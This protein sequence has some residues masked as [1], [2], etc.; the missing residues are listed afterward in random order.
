MLLI[1]LQVVFTQRIFSPSIKHLYEQIPHTFYSPNINS[2]LLLQYNSYPGVYSMELGEIQDGKYIPIHPNV[3]LDPFTLPGCNQYERRLIYKH[4]VNKS[5]QT[6]NAFFTNMYVDDN[7]VFVTRS[8]N[9]ILTFEIDLNM[10]DRTVNDLTLKSIHTTHGNSSE[11]HIACL[12]K[13]CAVFGQDS[14]F[15][16]KESKFKLIELEKNSQNQV[17]FPTRIY[18]DEKLN[19]L[20]LIYGTNMVEVYQFTESSL[21]RFTSF[22][23]GKEIV[24]VRT[25]AESTILYLLDKSVGLLAYKIL[26]IGEYIDTGFMIALQNCIQFDFY[27]NTFFLIAETTDRIP[28]A[29]EVLVDEDNYYFNK[30]Y[31]K[32]MEIYDVWVGEHVAILIGEENHRVIYHSV[33]NKFKIDSEIPLFFQ[34]ID[35]MNVEEFRKWESTSYSKNAIEQDPFSKTSLSYK[36]SFI[37][38]ISSQQ[39]SIF[40]IKSISP[41]LQ[42]KPITSNTLQ[43]Y[44]KMNSTNCP[45]KVKENEYSSFQQCVIM[46]NFTLV[47][48]EILFYEK[49]QTFV[50]IGGCALIGFVLLLI[51]AVV[52]VKKYLDNKIIDLSKHIK[53]EELD[54]PIN[55]QENA[56][57]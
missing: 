13:T 38:G 41:W 22:T 23:A 26:S 4:L 37:V 47:G 10:L 2:T 29:L 43:Y 39:L 12:N 42:C 15:L 25:N 9:S 55:P 17:N 16:Y 49:D 56:I 51:I 35:L 36:Q 20:Y 8:D 28:Y 40:S 46:H 5:A 18:F 50:I 1:L 27:E 19:A 6:N 24:S 11:H 32:D 7:F 3:T 33:Y 44:L 48:K 34:D 14:A 45:S 57:V 53:L 30:I 52:C 21:V 31:S 54:P